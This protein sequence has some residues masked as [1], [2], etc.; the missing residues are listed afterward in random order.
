VNFTKEVDQLTK[1]IKKLIRAPLGGLSF[2]RYS[3]ENCIH[4][5]V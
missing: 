5:T 4:L 3:K 2:C 1:A